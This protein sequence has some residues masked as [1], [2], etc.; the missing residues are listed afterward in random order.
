MRPQEREVDDVN[1]EEPEPADT[2]TDT[3][4]KERGETLAAARGHKWRP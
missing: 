1:R 3:P 2:P 4:N